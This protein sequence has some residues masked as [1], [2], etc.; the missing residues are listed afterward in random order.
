MPASLPAARPRVPPWRG[1]VRRAGRALGLRAALVLLNLAYIPALARALGAERYGTLAAAIGVAAI[2]LTAALAGTN[3]RL[4]V[5]VGRAPHDAARALGRHIWVRVGGGVLAALGC[6]VWALAVEEGRAAALLLAF[7]A[8]LPLRGLAMLYAA[9]LYGQ[10]AAPRVIGA[11]LV[12]RAAEAALVLALIAG[13]GAGPLAVPLV[14]ALAWAAQAVWLRRA[15]G[16]ARMPPD[17][18]AALRAA[19]AVLRAGAPYM[20]LG[21]SATFLHQSA[22]ITAPEA[23]SPPG[24]RGWIA[25][26]VNLL[27]V[28]LALLHSLLLSGAPVLAASAR[29]VT[30]AGPRLAVAGV[31]AACAAGVTAEA[32]L[33]L[34]G[35]LVVTPVLGADFAGVAGLSGPVAL[36]VAAFLAL[37]VLNAVAGYHDGAWPSAGVVAAAAAGTLALAMSGVLPAGPSGPLLAAAAGGWAAA[38]GQALRYARLRRDRAGLTAALLLPPPIVAVLAHFLRALPAAAGLAAAAALAGVLLFLAARALRD[39]GDMAE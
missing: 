18:R 9:A 14:Q 2:F 22:V 32:G 6:A 17:P 26:A 23:L 27:S 25:V 8:V 37:G 13:A 28:A 7:A 24:A 15:A 39:A 4:T 19:G 21:A 29:D 1:V 38:L 35:P 11:E 10:G 36:M 16:P 31:L 20:V 5:E 34:A 3:W 12:A 30:P 33:R